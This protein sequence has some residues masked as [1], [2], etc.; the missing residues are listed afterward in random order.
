[1]TL[2]INFSQGVKTPEATKKCSKCG[3]IKQLDAFP[4]RNDRPS[5]RQARC[6]RPGVC[7]RE[8][9]RFGACIEGA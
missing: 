4:I 9:E 6:T 3:Q 1:M 2:K 5:G 7:Q 8:E